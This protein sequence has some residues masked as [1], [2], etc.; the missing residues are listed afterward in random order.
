[1][2]LTTRIDAVILIVSSYIQEIEADFSGDDKF[3]KLFSEIKNDLSGEGE[4]L[5]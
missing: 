1:M 2:R 4:V 3:T 5:Q